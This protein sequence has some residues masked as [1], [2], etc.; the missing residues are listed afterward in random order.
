MTFAFAKANEPHPTLMPFKREEFALLK[1]T[2][3][4]VENKQH[5]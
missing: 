1:R 5:F 3:F 2:Q 4:F